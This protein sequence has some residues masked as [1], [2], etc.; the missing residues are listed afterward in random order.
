MNAM[1]VGADQLGN[2]PRTLSEFGIRVNRHVSGRESA[3]QKKCISLPAG[4][5]LLILFTDFLGHNVM[6]S[7][8]EAAQ[9]DGV[10][11][12]CCRR[13]VCS[14]KQSL[15]LCGLRCPND[16]DCRGSTVARAGS[17]S[18]VRLP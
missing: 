9:R 2:I 13:S 15:E 5:D 12:V 10:R 17:V 14:V 16:A 6:R 7:F 3:H 8:R 1:L 4:I 11:I 18:K